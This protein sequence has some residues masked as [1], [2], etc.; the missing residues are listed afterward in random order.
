MFPLLHA[1]FLLLFSD[2]SFLHVVF[3]L[4]P[5]SLQ[6]AKITGVTA[7]GVYTVYRDSTNREMYEQNKNV[8]SFAVVKLCVL[9]LFLK[10]ENI[11][12]WATSTK[13]SELNKFTQIST[14]LFF[15][16][17]TT[18]STMGGKPFSLQYL[19]ATSMYSKLASGSHVLV[20]L[21]TKRANY[22]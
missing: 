8:P 1:V 20:D 16:C 11:W 21:W 17:S 4:P 3:L 2:A 12:R 7:T 10:K 5:P 6:K 14:L 13:Q 19:W 22:R 18:A 9:V 15:S